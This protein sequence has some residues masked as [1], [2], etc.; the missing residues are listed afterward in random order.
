MQPPKSRRL[1]AGR[2]IARF[3]VETISKQRLAIPAASGLTHLQFRRFAGCP[4]CS[5]HLRS[6]VRRKDELGAHGI[7]EVVFFH[8]SRDALLRYHAD[9]PF[10]TVADPTRKLYR[11]FGVERAAGALLHPAVWL[12][13]ARGILFRRAAPMPEAALTAFGLPADF[14]IDPRGRVLAAKYGRHADDQW[15]V[16]ELLGLAASVPTFANDEE[17]PNHETNDR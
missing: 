8:A 13:M 2:V 4:I 14:L 6:F 12:A 3:E 5:V 7:H 16:E 17:K 1:S 10:A 9:L 11:R 15:S